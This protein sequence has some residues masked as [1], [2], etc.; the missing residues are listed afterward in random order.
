MTPGQVLLRTSLLSFE[1]LKTPIQRFDR[2]AELHRN[3]PPVMRATPV[4]AHGPS[5]GQP[6]ACE[7]AGTTPLRRG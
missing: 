5:V 7:T 2:D 6:R 3:A 4:A 1:V